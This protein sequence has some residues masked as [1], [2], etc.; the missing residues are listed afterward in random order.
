MA[1]GAGGATPIRATAAPQAA[2]P[3]GRRDSSERADE[4][5]QVVAFL[6]DV[7]LEQYTLH[8]LRGGFDDME[9]LM[10]IEDSDMKDLG[11]PAFHVSRLRR[12][13]QDMQRQMG[14]C[15]E[16]DPNHPVVAFLEEN[17]LGQYAKAL[18]RNGFDDMDTLCDIEDSDLKDLG[19]PRGHV[20][21]FQKRLREFQLHQ[22]SQDESL[23]LPTLHASHHSVRQQA[24][25]P[26]RRITREVPAAAMATMPTA[27]MKS[28]VERSWDQVQAL[29]TYAVAEMLYRHTFNLMPEAIQLFPS[30]VRMKYR[31]WSADEARDE[32][33]VFDS[34]AL[35][36]LFGKFIN[37]VGCAVAG[38]HDNAKLVPMLTQLGGRH[39]NYGVHASHFQALGKAF[40]RTL[41][42]IL[43]GE[44]TQEVEGAWTMAYNFMSSIMLE[45]LRMAMHDKE[46]ALNLHVPPPEADKGSFSEP[47]TR[48]VSDESTSLDILAG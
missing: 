4:H 24:P 23:Y 7:G 41:A 34:P 22:F 1:Q 15:D 33:N 11:L 21:K 42:E 45:G 46:M 18:L 32:S 16:G 36:K 30:H 9:T 2:R 39:V 12:H 28:A 8:F 44:F 13:L 10:A 35:R 25:A 17:G 19:I 3:G 5:N 27:Q 43:G 14:P 29:G 47:S 6:K 40:N 20:L 31:E 38:L 48:Q 26:Q 37:A